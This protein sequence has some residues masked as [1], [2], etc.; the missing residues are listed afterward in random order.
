MSLIHVKI[1]FENSLLEGIGHLWLFGHFTS[2]GFHDGDTFGAVMLG[3]S[4]LGEVVGSRYGGALS[5]G[6]EVLGQVEAVAIGV[7]NVPIARP[8]VSQSTR[9]EAEAPAE[10]CGRVA[11]GGWG[12][13]VLEGTFV[14]RARVCARYALGA[15]AHVE[16]GGLVG[17]ARE[18]ERGDGEAT[19]LCLG[20]GGGDRAGVGRAALAAGAAEEVL[21][22]LASD[23]R[24]AAL[25]VW[26]RR[27]VA[28]GGHG[29]RWWWN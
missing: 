8:H 21:E 12:R 28:V 5:A 11:R 7:A 29:W 9:A 23:G 2:W 18:A 22:C 19:A 15:R 4:W 13:I 1:S 10:G 24:A 20:G 27:R 3:T 14:D 25:A 16:W 6:A 17:R 26:Q